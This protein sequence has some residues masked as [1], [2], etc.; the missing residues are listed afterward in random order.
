MQSAR[1]G[2]RSCGFA[3]ALHDIA[4]RYLIFTADI[5]IIEILQDKMQ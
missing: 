4:N 1:L 3:V 5:G 2:I